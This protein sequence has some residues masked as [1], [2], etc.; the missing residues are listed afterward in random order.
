MTSLELSLE[1]RVPQWSIPAASP[2]LR[3]HSIPSQWPIKMQNTH[4]ACTTLKSGGFIS[5]PRLTPGRIWQPP[6]FEI[7][8]PDLASPHLCSRNPLPNPSL[9]CLL[10]SNWLVPIERQ[11]RLDKRGLVLYTHCCPTPLAQTRGCRLTLSCLKQPL[12]TEEPGHP[13][14]WT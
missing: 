4:L 1:S 14:C 13:R 2:P 10:G 7:T 9:D 8:S 3:C 6:I 12:W 5:R 11:G